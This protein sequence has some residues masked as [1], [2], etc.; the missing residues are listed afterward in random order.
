MWI[1]EF[2]KYM[3]QKTVLQSITFILG[4]LQP[5][6]MIQSFK[7]CKNVNF[8]LISASFS[9]TREI[10]FFSK[11]FDHINFLHSNILLHENLKNQFL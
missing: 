9:S 11:T 1:V 4:K 3:N 2:A 5:K 8:S 10:R 6:L 7:N